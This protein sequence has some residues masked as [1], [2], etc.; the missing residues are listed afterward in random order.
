[1]SGR[2]RIELSRQDRGYPT[3][4]EGRGRLCAQ[5]CCVRR[6]GVILAALA[7]VVITMGALVAP[8]I[9]GRITH[10]RDTSAFQSYVTTFVGGWRSSADPEGPERDDAWAADH[11]DEVLAEGDRA[12]DWLAQRPTAP[13]VDPSGK[14]DVSALANGYLRVANGERPLPLSREGRRTVI[15]GAW[16]YLCWSER[17]DKSSPPS[18]EED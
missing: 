5:P 2:S 17:G 15:I 3:G 16:A 4:I 12:C 8:S 1:M 10:P 6:R 9:A 13:E 14:S 11:P 18:L 7:A